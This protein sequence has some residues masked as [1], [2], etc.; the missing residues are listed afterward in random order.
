MRRPRIRLFLGIG[1]PL[2]VVVVLLAAWAIDSSSAS[3]TVERNVTLADRDIGK[4]AEDELAATVADVAK[5]FESSQVEVRAPDKTYKVAAAELGLRLDQDA[6]VQRALELDRGRSLPMRPIA[7]LGSFFEHRKAPL[8]FTVDAAQLESGL[9]A[10]GGDAAATEPKLVPGASGMTIVSGSA[11]RLLDPAGARTALERAAERGELPLVIDVEAQDRQ[12]TVS[13]AAA[14]AVADQLTA[15]TAKGL[16]VVAGPNRATLP[17]PTVR[18][19]LGSTVTAGKL[20]PTLDEKRA[21]DDVRRA[22]PGATKAKDASITLQGNQVVITPSQDGTTCCAADTPA[23][24]LAAITK[25]TGTADL[26]LEVTKADF[27]TED[28]K[29]LGIKEP[30]GGVTEWKGQPQVKS[31]T[32]YYQPGAPRVT[33]IHR[34]ADLVRGTLVLPGETFS[35][36]GTVGQRTEAKGFVVAGAIA[37][38]EHV[39][40]VGGGVSQFA[41]TMFNAAFFAGLPYVEYQAHSEHFDRYPFGREAT[42]GYEHPDMAWKNNTP[43]GILVWTSYTD[44]SVTVTLWSTQYASGAQTGQ[45]TSRSGFCT[46]VTTERTITYVDGRTAKDTVHARYRDPGHTTC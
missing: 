33:N 31:F 4:L 3:G 13:D 42:M 28:A 44:T 12:P 18:S 40:E 16:V 6:T 22:L 35:V 15:G 39:E 26:D 23:R 27:T 43:Y 21:L 5:E 36:N 32:T 11:G 14:Q 30:V 34:I 8:V 46:N 41:T 29:K 7:W 37:N 10:L 24:L 9:A 20:T 2:L 45:S 1:I 38:G 25:G 17:A 19:W